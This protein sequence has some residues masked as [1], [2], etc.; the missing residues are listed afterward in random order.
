MLPS[1]LGKVDVTDFDEEMMMLKNS[2]SFLGN[3]LIVELKHLS[4]LDYFKLEIMK[5]Y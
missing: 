2:I 3:L 4:S 1:T 5:V